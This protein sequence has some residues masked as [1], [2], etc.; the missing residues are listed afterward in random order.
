MALDQEKVAASRP[1][2]GVL[3]VDSVARRGSDD[4]VQPFSRALGDLDLSVRA[5]GLAWSDLAGGRPPA[6][7][8]SLLAPA[9]RL[10]RAIKN[11]AHLPTRRSLVV[12][13]VQKLPWKISG[14]LLEGYWLLVASI[15]PLAYLGAPAWL[16]WKL[17]WCFAAIALALVLAIVSYFSGVSDIPAANLRRTMLLVLWPAIF[18]LAAPA[19]GAGIV[20]FAWFS[21]AVSRALFARWP[22]HV[23]F[24]DG[25]PWSVYTHGWLM[26]LV[27]LGLLV[28]AAV[29]IL[30]LLRRWAGAVL[31]PSR[32]TRDLAF[33]LGD[34]A[35]RQRAQNRLRKEIAEH[36]RG[37][38][39]LVLAAHGISSVL[40]IDTLRRYGMPAGLDRLILVTAGS[41]LKRLLGPVFTLPY[42]APS[43]LNAMMR[44]KHSGLHWINVYR[45]RDPI[46]GNLG[47]GRGKEICIEQQLRI[48]KAHE[49][50]WSD[51][52]VL[53]RVSEHVEMILRASDSEQKRSETP[54]PSPD[55]L[56]ANLVYARPPYIDDVRLVDRRAWIA[57]AVAVLLSWGAS[58]PIA[59]AKTAAALSAA[60]TRG[61][62]GYVMAQTDRISKLLV[63]PAFWVEYW[64]DPTK[65]S[66]CLPIDATVNRSCMLETVFPTW[67][68]DGPN[69]EL[70]SCYET[71]EHN[72]LRRVEG[73]FVT[74]S[75]EAA[76]G[77]SGPATLKACRVE[78]RSGSL[79][80]WTYIAIAWLAPATVALLLVAP[81]Y[82]RPLPGHR[83]ATR[84]PRHPDRRAS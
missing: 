40:A 35:H 44:R 36:S 45:S 64:P 11:A 52:H 80:R 28:S 37:V 50:Y 7:S 81:C 63:R 33:Y 75:I 78:Q 15:G 22:R 6:G 61:F 84:R 54:A 5:S 62:S 1:H 83:F 12:A 27:G 14:A 71:T 4:L 23:G 29:V 41:P 3:L 74:A 13:E 9:A 21:R 72:P 19:W 47:L 10:R 48:D 20:A 32:F 8:G 53:T 58:G 55:D 67:P 16:G 79:A 68:S 38:V 73:R 17:A 18:L 76:P 43:Y 30:K 70:R 82:R 65:P 69:P 46:G 25:L 57:A 31:W 49:D 59:R 66:V 60:P 77:R 34:H 56:H 26:L 24:E 39:G 2:I 42:P 51:A